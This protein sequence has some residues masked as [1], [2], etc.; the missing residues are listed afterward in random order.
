MAGYGYSNVTDKGFTSFLSELSDGEWKGIS[1]KKY[2]APDQVPSSPLL[3]APRTVVWKLRATWAIGGVME[4]IGSASPGLLARL[5]A[6]WDSGQRALNLRLASALEHKDE[7]HRAAAERLR[8]ALLSG[9]GAE[10]TTLR[11]DQEVDFGGH[12]VTIASEEPLA[13]DVKTVGI[14][15]HI[16]RIR[17]ATAALGAGLGRVPGQNRA[18]S[19]SRQLRDA[20]SVCSTAFNAIHDE[21]EWLLEHTAEGAGR[22]HLKALQAPFLMLLDRYPAKSGSPVNATAPGDPPDAAAPKEP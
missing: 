21:M 1:I 15:E 19:R 8:K 5:D 16:E 7:K 4:A 3:D 17:E 18:P 20:L 11:L 6:E 12:Q 10:Q 2:D 13:A 22:D 14:Q 9:S